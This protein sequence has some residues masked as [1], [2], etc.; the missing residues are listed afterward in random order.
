MSQAG[1][2]I[3]NGFIGPKFAVSRSVRQS[4]PLSASLYVLCI[5]P[6]AI[7]IHQNRGIL[8][9]QATIGLEQ[10]RLSLYADDTNTIITIEVAIENTLESFD[11]YGRGSG[12]KPNLDTC[13]G[14]WLGA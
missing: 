6:L 12:A 3:V 9:L 8:G 7:G 5:E 2:V 11:L 1:S 14:L 10:I 13:K 4:C